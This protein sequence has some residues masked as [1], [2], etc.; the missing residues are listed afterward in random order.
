MPSKGFA[1]HTISSKDLV[2]LHLPRHSTN[3]GSK[4]S[5][6]ASVHSPSVRLS[7]IE[8]DGDIPP[9]PAKAHHRPFHRRWNLGDPPSISFEISPPKYSVWDATGPKG[10]KLSDVRNNKY[11]ARRGG[12]KRICLILVLLVAL[13]VGLA[14]GLT[15][16][17][18]KK[19]SSPPVPPQSPENTTLTPNA[20]EPFPAGSYTLT[21]FLD[22]VQTGCSSQTEDWSCFPY[23]TYLESPSEAMAN[24]T[25]VITKAEDG[26]SIASTNNPWSLNFDQTPLAMLDA[27]T[28]DERYQFNA[29]LNKVTVPS[30]GVNCF[31]NDTNLEGNLYTKKAPNYL[32]AS[33]VDPSNTASRDDFTP[34]PYA[35]DI[36]QTI[37]GGETVPE[38][39]R[40]QANRR[41]DRIT[42][43]FTPQPDSSICSCEY[44]NFGS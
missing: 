10:E 2:N 34:W 11:I 31:F 29:A 42:D 38:C 5:R 20:T 36:R 18:R 13:I 12:W 15:V 14:V 1:S 32:Q 6:A 4:R 24:F 30:V 25:W 26:F 3:H 7:I 37:G 39:F 23:H 44:R 16:G 43:G 28:D 27:G 21:T 35:V 33:P 8:E 22:T 40:L 9:L 19:D 41:G 17:L